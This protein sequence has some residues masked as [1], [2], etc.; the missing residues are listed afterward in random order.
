MVPMVGY[1]GTDGVDG[2]SILINAK[3]SNCANG[4]N[5]FDIGQDSNA[6]G[7]L[8]AIEV[9]ISVDLCNGADGAQDQQ[10]HGVGPQGPPGVNGTNGTDGHKLSVHKVHPELTGM[11]KV[12]SVP[13]PAGAD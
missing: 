3:T 1:N 6:D 10:G 9:V 12:L 5:A 8:S 11:G 2:K 4:G 7:V 13:G